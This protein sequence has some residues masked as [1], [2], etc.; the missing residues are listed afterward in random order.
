M[1]RHIA[2]PSLALV[3]AAAACGGGGDP[4]DSLDGWKVV[5]GRISPSLSSV[6]AARA[7]AT[8]RVGVPFT[9]T[10]TTVGSGSCTRAAGARVSRVNARFVV[11]E[12]LDRERDGTCTDD[13]ASYP[14]DVRVTF[15]EAGDAVVRVSGRAFTPGEPATV[16]LPVRVER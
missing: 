10:V 5:V 1:R 7:P 16:D 14:R 12:P 11:V 2:V 4:L 9:V 6:Q 8:A 3:L 13:L 15:E